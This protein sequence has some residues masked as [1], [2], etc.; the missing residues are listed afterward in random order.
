VAS[1]A[2]ERVE[3][4]FGPTKVIHGVDVGIEDGEC[5]V[6]GMTGAVKE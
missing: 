2:I 4:A 5:C 3:K 6:A 1:V